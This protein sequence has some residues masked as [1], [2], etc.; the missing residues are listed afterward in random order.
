MIGPRRAQDD[1]GLLL[2]DIDEQEDDE[3]AEWV[4]CQKLLKK[5]TERCIIHIE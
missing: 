2:D 3:D 4:R 5:I 1:D